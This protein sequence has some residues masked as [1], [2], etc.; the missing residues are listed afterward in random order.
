MRAFGKAFAKAVDN[1]FIFAFANGHYTFSF[2]SKLFGENGFKSALLVAAN[3]Y[4]QF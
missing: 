2:V 3:R 4:H 1:Y